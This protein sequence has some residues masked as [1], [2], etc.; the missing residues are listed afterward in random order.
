MRKNTVTQ[1]FRQAFMLARFSE[2]ESLIYLLKHYIENSYGETD[3]T[4]VH[5]FNLLTDGALMDL[6]Q[7][8]TLEQGLTD[9]NEGANND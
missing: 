8:I 4:L 9:G 3:L 5:S 6:Y 1:D 7:A 2:V